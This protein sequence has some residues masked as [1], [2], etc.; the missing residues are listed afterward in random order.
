MEVVEHLG[1][2]TENDVDEATWNIARLSE[3]IP[4]LPNIYLGVYMNH[5]TSSLE[6]KTK[7]MLNN[8]A[9]PD[10][11]E[12]SVDDFLSFHQEVN[13]DA[14]YLNVKIYDRSFD[15]IDLEE[16]KRVSVFF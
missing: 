5:V 2:H 6:A 16:V 15:L 3:D 1:S 10:E 12:Y 13:Y 7:Q 14:S 8:L 4:E 9:L 11:Y